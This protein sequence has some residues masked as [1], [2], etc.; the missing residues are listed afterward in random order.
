MYGWKTVESNLFESVKVFVTNQTVEL[1]ATDFDGAKTYVKKR[2]YD[3]WETGEIKPEDVFVVEENFKYFSE[4][5]KAELKS[6]AD[7]W[8]NKICEYWNN[9]VIK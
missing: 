7:E 5:Q 1:Y 9:E 8:I 4:E 2:A 3:I 6:I